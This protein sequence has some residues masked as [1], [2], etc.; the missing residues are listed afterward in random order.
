MSTENQSQQ[1]KP[2]QDPV[3]CYQAQPQRNLLHEKRKNQ[4]GEWKVERSYEVLSKL[5]KGGFAKVYLAKDISSSEQYAIKVVDKSSLEKD[6]FKEKLNQEIKIQKSL[7]HENVVKYYTSFEDSQNVYIV[8]EY[9]SN[10]TFKELLDRRK[11]LTEIEV[12]SHLFQIIQSLKY[13]H[14]KGVIH[15]DLKIANIFLNDK[16]VVKLADFGLSAMMKNSQKRKTVCGTPN[17]IAPEVLKNQ[18]H[19]YLVDNWAIGVIVYTFLIGKPPFEEKEVE[20]TLRNIKA[21]RYSFPENCTISKEAKDF[22]QK[23]LVPNPDQRLTMDQMLQHPFMKSEEYYIPK[24]FPIST[25]ALPPTANYLRKLRKSESVLAPKS[26]LQLANNGAQPYDYNHQNENQTPHISTTQSTKHFQ[27]SNHFYQTQ[28]SST[29]NFKPTSLSQQHA[30]TNSNNMQDTNSTNTNENNTIS[31]NNPNNNEINIANQEND[32][33]QLLRMR[34][35]ENIQFSRQFQNYFQGKKENSLQKYPSSQQFTGNPIS[36]NQNIL[37]QHQSPPKNINTA[38]GYSSVEKPSFSQSSQT[39]VPTLTSSQKF[40]VKKYNTI[41]I[42]DTNQNQ[43]LNKANNPY[44]NLP[45]QNSQQNQNQSPLDQINLLTQKQNIYLFDYIDCSSKFGLAYYLNNGNVGILLNDGNVTQIVDETF[46]HIQKV[47]DNYVI[48]KYP[49]K[50]IPPSCQ[51]LFKLTTN[52]KEYFLN[53]YKLICPKAEL[54]EGDFEKEVY[55]KKFISTKQASFFRF[56]NK[57]LQV[58]FIDKSEVV[59]TQQ[60]KNL[61]FK[62]K[63]GTQKIHTLNHEDKSSLPHNIRKRILYIKDVFLSGNHSKTQQANKQQGTENQ[64][65]SGQNPTKYS[66]T[67]PSSNNQVQPSSVPCS[68]PIQSLAHSSSQNQKLTQA[69]NNIIN[70][71]Q[72]MSASSLTQYQSLPPQNGQNQA[73]MYNSTYQQG[74]NS[75]NP[76]LSSLSPLSSINQN[77]SPAMQDPT[78]NNSNNLQ[79]NIQYSQMMKTNNNTTSSTNNSVSTQ[80][81]TPQQQVLNQIKYNNSQQLSQTA[82][83]S[84]YQSQKLRVSVENYQS[85]VSKPVQNAPSLHPLKIYQ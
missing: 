63:T 6:S 3:Q 46:E 34:S 68:P 52:I 30:T 12:K 73:S 1:Q 18:G 13:I 53:K 49:I 35:Q 20:N 70:P 62:D 45:S 29:A 25:L 59:I 80:Q 85:P 51:N 56:S 37:N 42:S 71:A 4:D 78:N 10:Q 19:D 40:D 55:L 76:Q 66:S 74:Y 23:I 58:I 54:Q 38:V 8:L 39:K 9:C 41:H 32:N 82:K 50:Q 83:L 7:N 44:Y 22:I 72:Q 36:S 28:S 57:D 24:T 2:A 17:Y 81:Q 21:N 31:S 26:Q 47:Q 33:Y 69:A 61:Y 79:N 67:T 43:N 5:G 16:M 48:Q 64:Q 11:R 77:I 14:S 84:L 27:R 75:S 15:R 65:N 60:N